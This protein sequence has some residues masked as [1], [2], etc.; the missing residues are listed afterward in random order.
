MPLPRPLFL[1]PLLPLLVLTDI[2][3]PVSTD[4][5]LDLPFLTGIGEL[6]L[7]PDAPL[8]GSC[9]ERSL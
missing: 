2:E 4:L 8:G 7:S 6:S 3:D 9:K 5:D 1:P